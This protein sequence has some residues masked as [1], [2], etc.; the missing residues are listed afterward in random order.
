MR[1]F[2]QNDDLGELRCNMIGDERQIQTRVDVF[3]HSPPPHRKR[4]KDSEPFNSAYGQPFVGMGACS[5]WCLRSVFV[6]HSPLRCISPFSDC[7]ASPTCN[8]G[9]QLVAFSLTPIHYNAD[10]LKHSK[11]CF[12]SLPT[13]FLFTMFRHS[14]Q[15][16]ISPGHTW[17][18]L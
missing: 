6:Q 13:Q 7:H 18:G 3:V 12:P 10:T 14:L 1:L 11:H 15:L 5:S 4:I 8:A 2:S 17:P 16:I 9:L